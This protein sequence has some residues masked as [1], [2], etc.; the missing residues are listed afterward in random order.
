MCVREFEDEN[1]KERILRKISVCISACAN[2]LLG[3]MNKY[4]KF[5]GWNVERRRLGAVNEECGLC[6][7]LVFENVL[8][9][10]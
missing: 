4:E 9:L 3:R 6:V 8:G 10:S 1:E 7:Y 5:C 2:M